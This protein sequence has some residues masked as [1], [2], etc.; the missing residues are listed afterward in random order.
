M[1]AASAMQH[2]VLGTASS[3]LLKNASQ[4]ISPARG[5][6]Q[7]FFEAAGS[8][9]GEGGGGDGGEEEAPSP[10]PSCRPACPRL[11]PQTG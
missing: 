9:A 3:L 7:L 2:D 6:A 10:P 11:G 1:K 5:I 8:D 4:V